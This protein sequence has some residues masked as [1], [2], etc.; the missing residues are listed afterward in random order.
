MLDLGSN[1][2]LPRFIGYA[3]CSTLVLGMLHNLFILYTLKKLR[4]RFYLKNN[5]YVRIKSNQAYTFYSVVVK[6]QLVQG[7]T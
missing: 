6:M 4:V 5:L 7:C 1:A 3:T 2:I